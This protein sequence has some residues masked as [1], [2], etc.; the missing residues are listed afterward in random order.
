[1]TGTNARF[2]KYNQ[3]VEQ[4]TSPFPITEGPSVKHRGLYI[5][6]RAVEDVMRNVSYRFHR[7]KPG[8]DPAQVET[9]SYQSQIDRAMNDKMYSLG[10]LSQ[11]IATWP[12]VQS[13]PRKTIVEKRY[14]FTVRKDAFTNY[15]QY[16]HIRINNDGQT[17][18]YDYKCYED[19][20]D[21][22]RRIKLTGDT[23]VLNR[24]GQPMVSLIM[25][26]LSSL[27][28]FDRLT[29]DSYY[30]NL[31]FL[32]YRSRYRTTILPHNEIK[33]LLLYGAR[34]PNTNTTFWTFQDSASD[35][36]QNDDNE[37]EEL[38]N[39][40]DMQQVEQSKDQSSKPYTG[41]RIGDID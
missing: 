23:E 29:P 2:T 16:P 14:H 6:G 41:P 25:I 22:R 40:M 5:F 35:D 31:G 1:M 37:C 20:P 27:L 24:I 32:K 26:G 19:E 39:D 7:L 15:N 33:N 9:V 10:S 34:I 11:F 3:S 36:N 13:G 21:S 17:G 28:W 8:C 12:T 18:Q 38:D 4:V 30:S